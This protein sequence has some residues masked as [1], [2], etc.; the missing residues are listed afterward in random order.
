MHGEPAHLLAAQLY[1]PEV[2]AGAALETQR[3]PPSADRP[4]AAHA[5]HRSVEHRKEGIPSGVDLATTPAGELMANHG[6]VAVEH[7]PPALIPQLED[8]SRGADD[9]VEQ[10]RQDRAGRKDAIDERAQPALGWSIEDSGTDT[11]CSRDKLRAL[12]GHSGDQP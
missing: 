3:P 11:Q 7:V 2:R 6:P 5:G 12:A 10:Q 9:V 4:C 8:A 1:L